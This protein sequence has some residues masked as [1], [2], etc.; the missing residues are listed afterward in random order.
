MTQQAVPLSS[1]SPDP[2]IS[3]II[4]VF[5]EEENLEELGDRLICTLTAMVAP[6]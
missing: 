1:A 2:Y 4:P 5:N 6:S 3:V